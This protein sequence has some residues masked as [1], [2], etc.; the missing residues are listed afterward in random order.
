MQVFISVGHNEFVQFD[1]VYFL[2]TPFIVYNILS[3]MQTDVCIF[4]NIK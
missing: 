1:T 4:H 3:L 2:F